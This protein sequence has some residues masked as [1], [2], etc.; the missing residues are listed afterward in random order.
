MDPKVAGYRR[1]Q[2]GATISL[3]QWGGHERGT[4]RMARSSPRKIDRLSQGPARP[5]QRIQV[6]GIHQIKNNGRANL[7]GDGWNRVSIGLCLAA[8][9]TTNRASTALIK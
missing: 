8:E 5:K 1:C 4:L 7:A 3:C 6:R 2:T 9:E